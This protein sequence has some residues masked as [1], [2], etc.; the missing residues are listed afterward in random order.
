[1]QERCNCSALAME[2]RLSCTNPSICVVGCRCPVGIRTTESLSQWWWLVRHTPARYCFKVIR[3]SISLYLRSSRGPI[4][5]PIRVTTYEVMQ[6]HWVCFDGWLVETRMRAG[7]DLLCG[8]SHI[9][10]PMNWFTL[11]IIRYA[12][13][14]YCNIMGGQTF[15]R[16]FL[17]CTLQNIRFQPSR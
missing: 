9:E 12:N 8:T 14:F 4:C 11:T 17:Y 6:G 15:Y 7:N 10:I 2:L 1:M 16:K 3:S 5:P 13:N